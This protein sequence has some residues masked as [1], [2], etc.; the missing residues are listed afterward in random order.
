MPQTRRHPQICSRL[1]S[2]SKKIQHS[3]ELR[4][5]IRAQ[6]FI[7]D[8]QVIIELSQTIAPSRQK[9]HISLDAVIGM[10]RELEHADVGRIF[11]A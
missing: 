1:H 7:A 3:F 4:C 8:Y 10:S 2:A 6:I 5:G 9:T 11:E